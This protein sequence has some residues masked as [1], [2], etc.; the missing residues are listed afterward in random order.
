MG[1]LGGFEWF[2]LGQ[3]SPYESF[4]QGLEEFRFLWVGFV[5]IKILV[6]GAKTVWNPET[7][8]INPDTPEIPDIPDLSPDIPGFCSIIDVGLSQIK[9]EGSVSQLNEIL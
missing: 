4:Y 1:V 8:G 5:S 7:P 3:L 2:L 9:L 6:L